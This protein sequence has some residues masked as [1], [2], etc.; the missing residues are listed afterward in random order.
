MKR[1]LLT[2]LAALALLMVAGSAFGQTINLRA[3]VPFDF[4]MSNQTLPS[5][6]YAIRYD[7]K[8]TILSVQSLDSGNTT[9]VMVSN[10]VGNSLQPAERSKLVFHHYG[11]VY[12]LREIC[13]AGYG[14]E[15]QLHKTS[16][17][18]EL[19]RIH[20]SNDAIVVASRR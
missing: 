5:G 14:K 2:S 3:N 11:N 6:E 20:S 17:E 8:G 12:F 19:E 15:Y 18:A 7:V 13:Q 9:L 16:R 4:I 10:S 1:Q